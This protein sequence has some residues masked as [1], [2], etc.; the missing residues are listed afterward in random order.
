[1]AK[2]TFVNAINLC[3]LEHASKFT[4]IVVGFGKSRGICCTHVGTGTVLLECYLFIVT[5]G[6]S[7]SENVGSF[8]PLS[9]NKKMTIL[10]FLQTMS[11]DSAKSTGAEESLTKYSLLPTIVWKQWL[12]H[13]C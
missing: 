1:M 3:L 8:L 6:K 2:M 9:K 13:S 7:A 5:V 12:T 11:R 4:H 10:P